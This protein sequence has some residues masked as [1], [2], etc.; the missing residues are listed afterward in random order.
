MG[1]GNGNGLDN[2]K[3]NLRICSNSQNQANR[4]VGKNNT[5]GF[6]GVWFDNRVLRWRAA[7][8]VLKKR[9]QLGKF[10]LKEDA[11]RAYNKAATKYFG[12]FALLNRI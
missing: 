1:K 10:D 12:E 11:A 2:R 4:G 9:I 5:S 3:A 6:K 7:I 8:Q